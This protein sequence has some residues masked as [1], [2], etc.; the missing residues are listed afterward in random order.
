MGK[1][2]GDVRYGDSSTVVNSTLFNSK[3]F[4]I[5]LG[6]CVLLSACGTDKGDDLDQFMANASSDMRVKIEPIPEVKPYVPV[7]YNIDGSLHDPFKSRKAQSSQSGG[8]QPNLSR[9]REPLEAFPLESLKYV[10]SLSKAKLKYALIQPP[11]NVVQEVKLGS[12]LGQNFGVVTEITENSV[13][14]KEIIQDDAT[15]DWTERSTSI[16]LQE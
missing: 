12:Y 2:M 5:A 13:V 10:G 1:K 9:P 14:L 16:N 6:L 11:D 7:G 15:G 3:D 4:F 8:L